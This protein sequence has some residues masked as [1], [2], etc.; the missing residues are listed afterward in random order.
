M[1]GRSFGGA[2]GGT[3]GGVEGGTYGTDPRPPRDQTWIVGRS[4]A[5]AIRPPH[6]NITIGETARF[7]FVFQQ[8]G[9]GAHVERYEQLRDRI[10]YASD[11]VTTGRTYDGS[12]WFRERHNKESLVVKV[13]PG[14]DIEA[15]ARGIWGIIEG[16]NDRTNLAQVSAE[17]SVEIFVLAELDQ[18]ATREEVKN[19]LE[20]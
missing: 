7:D 3:Y 1:T 8:S 18:Y 4:R 17:I 10:M 20:R 15:A 6:P 5:D 2:G 14:P 13:E 9:V 19:N 12:P 16:G 11:T